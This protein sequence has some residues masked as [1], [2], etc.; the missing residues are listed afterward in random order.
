MLLPGKHGN[1]SDYHYGLQG[2]EMDNE[3]KGEGNSYDFGTRIYDPRVGRF[4]A[5][6][7]LFKEYPH[8]SPYAFSENSVQ[9][10]TKES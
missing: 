3:I 2:Q 7:P 9:D 6:D 8:N 5:I 10:D 1:T 4:F